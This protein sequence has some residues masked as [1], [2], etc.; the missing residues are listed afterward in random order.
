MRYLR[1]GMIAV[2]A[3]LT[4]SSAAAATVMKTPSG[5]PVSVMLRGSKPPASGTASGGVLV[6]HGGP[7]LKGETPYLIFWTPGSHG[8][9]G[10]N[11]GLMAQY[12][13]DVAHD[14]NG[15]SDT[16]VYSVLGQ[17]GSPYNQTFS[18]SQV[19]VDTTP[20]PPAKNGCKLATGITACVSDAALQAEIT[21]VISQHHLPL[22]AAGAATTPIFF[23]ITPADTNVC[24][25]SGACASN[26]FCAYH[27]YFNSGGNSILYASVP[28][29]VF[30]SSTKGCQ[31]DGKTGYNTPTGPSG[32]Q[33]YNVADDLSHELSET[34]TDPL[35]SA[36]YTNGGLE[37]G[38]L[39]EAWGATVNTSKGYSPLSYGPAYSNSAGGIYDQI[40][41]GDEYY[42]QTE[43][44]NSTGQCETGL[45]AL[46]VPSKQK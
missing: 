38:D 21:N 43:F 2:T 9:S 31:T 24:L 8:I 7:V 17:Y 45:Q 42:N 35:I 13:T 36:W 33:A 25:S 15:V 20:Y 22:S 11:E 39:C 5:H 14:S 37:V 41:N 44:S 23:M 26:N 18:S 10:A 27:D 19:I 46:P 6:P 40:I 3:S 12:L 32:L 29:A 28:F 34:I 4:L 30:A 16:N 1:M